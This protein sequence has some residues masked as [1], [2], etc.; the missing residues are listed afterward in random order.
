LAKLPDERL[1]NCTLV[2]LPK[3]QLLAAEYSSS[4]RSLLTPRRKIRPEAVPETEIIAT[5][6]SAERL[7]AYRLISRGEGRER[8][9]RETLDEVQMTRRWVMLST[10]TSAGVRFRRNGTG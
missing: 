2:E 10:K 7:V 9:R 3:N 6:V 4:Y 5:G 1:C 8:P